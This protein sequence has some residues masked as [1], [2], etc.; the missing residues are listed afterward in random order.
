ML[1]DF[2]LVGLNRMLGGLLIEELGII[3]GVSGDSK[4]RQVNWKKIHVH[5]PRIGSVLGGAISLRLVCSLAC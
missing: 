4:A 3:A 1:S 2:P 5:W